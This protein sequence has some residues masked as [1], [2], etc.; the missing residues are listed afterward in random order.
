M[1]HNWFNFSFSNLTRSHQACNI[2]SQFWK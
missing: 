1:W 2:S